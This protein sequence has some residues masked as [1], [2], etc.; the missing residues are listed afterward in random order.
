MLTQIRLESMQP[1]LRGLN[2][3]LHCLVPIGKMEF[4]DREVGL[5][6]ERSCRRG[7]PSVSQRFIETN[8]LHSYII[9]SAYL[10]VLLRTRLRTVRWTF[11]FG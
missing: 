10:S 4:S 8:P 11:V 5:I 3:S 7:S 1:G 9:P 6:S 2:V